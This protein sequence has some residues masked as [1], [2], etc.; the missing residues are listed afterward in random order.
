MRN[1]L[2]IIGLLLGTSLS[3]LA[4]AV[5]PQA[6]MQRVRDVDD[7]ASRYSRTVIAT[8]RYQIKA[9]KMACAEKPRVKVIEGASKDYGSNGKDSRNISIILQP[10]TE[11]GIGFLQY[12]YD[13]ANKDA[14][15]WMYLSA[16][17]KVKRIVSG[18]DDEPKSGT[19]F[20]SEISYEDLEPSHVEDYTYT[21]VKEEIYAG[22]PCWVIESLP[23]PQRARKSNYSRA[24]QWID[25][26]R[27]L[28]LQAQ[29]YDRGGRPIKHIVFSNIEQQN[30]IWLSKLLSVNNIQSQRITTMK[31]EHTVI[32]PAI[33]DALFELRTL[34]DGAYREQQLNTLRSSVQ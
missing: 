6:I 33:A 31:T 7:G 18:N 9:G 34:T 27:Y 32:N 13:D 21:L 16:M 28:L 1:F 2:V 24:T 8:C 19:M 4:A 26:E 11:K 29:L 23:K 3:A 12:D 20:G 30:G 5:D 17:G 10:V 25:K 22:R 15:Q 14:D